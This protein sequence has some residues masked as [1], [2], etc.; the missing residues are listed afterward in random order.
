MELWKM[1]QNLTTLGAELRSLNNDIVEKTANPAVKIE[2]IRSLKQNKS[3]IEERFNLL[4]V[5]IDRIETEQ[6]DK[7][8][9]QNPVGVAQN[10]EERTMAAKA[11]FIRG[12]L[13][14]GSIS[15]ETRNLLGA[16]G[17]S[18]STGGEKIL[19]TNMAKDLIHEPF[20]KNPLRD[21][22]MFT[23]EK[24]LVLPKIA[25][26][27][28]DDDFISDEETAKEIKLD[29]DQVEFGR[30]K[31][32]VKARISDTVLHGTDSNLVPF[33]ENAL[34]SGLAAKEKKVSF[35]MSPKSGEETLTFYKAGVKEVTGADKYK[36]IK[37]AL[38]DLHEDYREN[39]KIV[40]RYA[41]YL[42]IIETL[43]NGSAT[44]Y[45]APPEKVLGK[46]TQFCDSA[47]DPIV[48]DFQYSH[49]NYDGEIVYDS[50]KDVDKGEY[51]F[52]LTGWFDHKIK[53]KSAFR[54]AKVKTTTP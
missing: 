12:S 40:M 11:E 9:Q 4:K 29:G 36:A 23:N 24:G 31:F 30:H 35:T 13:V 6:R 39:A 45:E 14:G 27:L 28:D 15:D 49:F 7:I 17:Q 1:K 38:A 41:D 22:S 42:D 8:K 16:I 43:A 2:E 21:I 51:L 33:V 46:P 50:D 18:A 44:L 19:P 47:V 20:T 34:N 26:E 25:Y 53:L 3:D 48:G 10:N 52:V 5:E 37:A 32:K 54:I